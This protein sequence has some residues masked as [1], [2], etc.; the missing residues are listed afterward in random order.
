MEL[1]DQNGNIILMDANGITI[2]SAGDFIV[3]AAS[4]NVEISGSA[5]DLV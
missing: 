1:A 3:D 5:I 2:T 4:G